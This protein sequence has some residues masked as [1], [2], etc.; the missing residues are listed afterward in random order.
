MMEEKNARID[1]TM[2]GFE[3]HGIFSSMIGLDYGGIH[4]GFGGCG[5][6]GEFGTEYIK[7]LLKTV[8]V[9]Q[10]EDLKGKHVRVRSERMKVHAIGH[11]IEDKWFSPEELAAEYEE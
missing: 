5:M 1:N 6:G 2:L 4:Q 7:R 9:D 11:I 3:D 10:W 8:G